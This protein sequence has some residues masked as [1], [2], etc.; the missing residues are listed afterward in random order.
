MNFSYTVKLLSLLMPKFHNT[1]D[2]SEDTVS[3]KL[4][5]CTYISPDQG[6]ITLLLLNL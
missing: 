3:L 6:I 1:F 4:L 2:F 5:P